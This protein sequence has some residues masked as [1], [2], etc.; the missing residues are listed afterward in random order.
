MKLTRMQLIAMGTATALAHPMDLAAERAAG[1]RSLQIT[2]VETYCVRNPLPSHGGGGWVFIKI[3]TNSGIVGYGEVDMLGI[4]F[5]PP[6]VEVLIKDIVDA[7]VIGANPYRIETL[8]NK[9]YSLSYSH[10]PEF[11]KM[12]VISAIEMAC[13]DIV[14]KDV[15]RPVYDLLGGA[16]RERIRTYTYTYGKSVGYWM[17]K[18]FTAV[19]LDPLARDLTATEEFEQIIPYEP[20]LEALNKAETTIREMREEAG[21]KCDI[22]IGT[23]GQMTAAGAIRLAKRLEPYDPLWFEEP[24]PPE[25]MTEMAKV[26]RKTTIPI[27]T[28]ERLTTKYD[29][30]RLIECKAAA[31]FNFDLGHVGGILEAKKIAGM[32]EAH[33]LQISPHVWDGPIIA[34]ASVQIAACCPNFIIME[35]IAD[36]QDIHAELLKEPIEWNRGYIIPSLRPGIGYELNETAA[37]KHLW[38]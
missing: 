23:H 9:L 6:A 17:E 37:R 1:N 2:G 24:V 25:N 19:K 29:F 18:G 10:Y 28:G 7:A 22:L 26:A 5:R 15:N 12:G 13:W 35:S 8:Y 32:A 11:T 30:A 16:V 31:I 27:C 34:A 3:L 36:M 20:S 4:S 38:S 21:N 33:Y 14:G